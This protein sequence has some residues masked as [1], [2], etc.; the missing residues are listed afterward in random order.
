M[1]RQISRRTVIVATVSAVH[2]PLVRG[3]VG[4]ELRERKRLAQV[5]WTAVTSSLSH[6]WLNEQPAAFEEGPIC[7]Y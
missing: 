5:T 6:T 7:N 3:P 2:Y 1:W 4:T